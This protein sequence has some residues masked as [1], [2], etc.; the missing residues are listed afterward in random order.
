MDNFLFIFTVEHIILMQEIIFQYKNIKE[1]RKNI[2][3]SYKGTKNP[4]I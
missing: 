4:R 3:S 1:K 2:F